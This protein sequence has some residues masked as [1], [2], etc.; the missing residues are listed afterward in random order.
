MNRNYKNGTAREY[1]IMK[2]LEKEGWF[3]IRSAGSHS[4]IDII[5]MMP[6]VDYKKRLENGIIKEEQYDEYGISKV[7]FMKQDWL[8]K[9][10]VNGI[11]DEELTTVV[12][13][14]QSKKTGYLSPQE[15]KEKEELEQKLSINIEVM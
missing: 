12:R 5:A 2:K 9:P 7:N 6:F 11:S 8:S 15:R 10:V 3:C 13:F 4:P 1:R 14:I